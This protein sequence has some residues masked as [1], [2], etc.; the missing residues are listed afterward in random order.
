MIGTVMRLALAVLVAVGAA[1]LLLVGFLLRGG[2]SARPQPTA[3]EAF[4]ARRLRH[5]AIPR[6]MRER[7]NPVPATPEIVLTHAW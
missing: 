6:D 5:W 3:A 7:L 2:V 4:L 1:A